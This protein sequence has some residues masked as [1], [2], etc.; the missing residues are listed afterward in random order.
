MKISRTVF[1]L[2]SGHEHMLEMGMFNVQRKISPKV[3]KAELKFMRSA[4]CL[5][6]FYMSCEVS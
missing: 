1:N 5:V 3:D 6:M 4:R 2:H